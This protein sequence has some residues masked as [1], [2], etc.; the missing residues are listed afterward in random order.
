MP[1][2]H[3]HSYH[4]PA[5][6]TTDWHLPLNSNFE[7]LD[8]DVGVRDA[9]ANRGE[10]EPKAGAKFEATDSGAVYLGDGS[11]WVLVDRRVDSLTTGSQ[12]LTDR[13]IV[14]AYGS[15]GNYVEPF[16]VSEYSDLG[17]TVNAAFAAI[18]SGPGYG[19]VVMPPTD[20]D[21]STTI[22]LRA[23][24]VSLQ[25]SGM[26]ATRPRYTGSDAAFRL[27]GADRGIHGN[28]GLRGDGSSGQDLIEL[29]VENEQ[30]SHYAF[31]NI[32]L[33]NAGRHA[34]HEICHGPDNNDIYDGMYHT[35]YINGTGD[36]AIYSPDESGAGNAS[37]TFFNIQ[38]MTSRIR[39]D[40]IHDMSGGIHK[41]YIGVEGE[42]CVDGVNFR[43][44][45]GYCPI[46][47]GCR[48][49]GQGSH[50]FHLTN[51]RGALIQNCIS[52]NSGGHGIYLDSNN[53]EFKIENYY[54]TGAQGDDIR[55]R[56][57]GTQTGVLGMHNASTNID[58][59][60]DIHMDV[61]NKQFGTLDGS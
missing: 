28:F 25:G 58:R 31:Q 23:D 2:T 29:T 54:V 37:R 27:D 17:D 53:R 44:Q 41:R 15:G 30:I 24:Y 8:T 52:W 14:Y 56:D 35:I 7:N 10:Y 5:K 18:A 20:E 1:N 4:Q 42:P 36:H 11:E 19:K 22:H 43:V 13:S 3:N 16:P 33:E 45:N 57:S 38:S 26:W 39:G 51:T 12:R 50:S 49:E 55:I 34:I 59:G 21:F 47:L 32:Y 40:F 60:V 46:F 6:G 61:Q 48:G 9:D